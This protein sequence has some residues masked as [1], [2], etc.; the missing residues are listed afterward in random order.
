MQFVCKQHQPPSESLVLPFCLSSQ[1]ALKWHR[2]SKTEQCLLLFSK[3]CWFKHT[4]TLARPKRVRVANFMRWLHVVLSVQ[5]DS[6]LLAESNP[7]NPP[8]APGQSWWASVRVEPCLPWKR[9]V[10]WAEQPGTGQLYESSS[11]VVVF[12]LQI[13]FFTVQYCNQPHDSTDIYHAI[14]CCFPCLHIPGMSDFPA[15]PG[16]LSLARGNRHRG[17]GT[18]EPLKQNKTK[19]P[20]HTWLTS[21]CGNARVPN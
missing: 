14:H 19:R 9:S 2:L 1:R 10:A 7:A 18:G 5:N 13:L 21:W 4:V 6:L 15:P 11:F 20:S 17:P 12:C 8:D 16:A 3:P